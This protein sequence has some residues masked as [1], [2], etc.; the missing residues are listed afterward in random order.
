MNKP[1]DPEIFREVLDNLATGVCVI[2]RDGKVFIWNQGA[3][4]ISGHRQHEII[5]RHHN[6]VLPTCLGNDCTKHDAACPFAV[7]LHE[8]KPSEAEIVL[9][10]KQGHSVRVLMR[11]AAI[12]DLHGHIVAVASDFETKAGRSRREQDRRISGPIGSVDELTGFANQELTEFQLRENLTAISED[13]VVF[14]IICIRAEKFDHFRSAYGRE[15]TDGML[16]VIAQ[17][18]SQSFRPSDFI[19]RWGNE[20]FIAMLANCEPNNIRKAFE[21]VQKLI[22]RASIPWWGEQLCVNLRL[23]YAAAEANDTVASLIKRAESSIG[24]GSISTGAA[25]GAA[26]S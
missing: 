7:P 13:N 20:E 19:G 6:Y 1:H 14:G 10:H 5:G 26:G 24:Q 12:R 17:N 4:R 16:R 8:G 9:Q 18:L 21:R 2:D 22:H 3:E 23:G 11:F 15:A 25:A